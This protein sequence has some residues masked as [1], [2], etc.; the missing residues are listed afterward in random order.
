MYNHWQLYQI[1][2]T[3]QNE[4]A[5]TKSNDFGLHIFYFIVG[6]NIWYLEKYAKLKIHLL[7]EYI[8]MHLGWGSGAVLGCM[9]Q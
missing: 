2:A 6:N 9:C 4:V 1:T 3:L 7:F 5:F 8:T